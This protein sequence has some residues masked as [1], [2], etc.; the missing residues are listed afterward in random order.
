[1]KQLSWLWWGVLV[2]I[3]GLA[4]RVFWFTQVPKGM[5]RDEASL[6]YNAYSILKTGRDEYGKLLP[7]LFTS[8]GDQKLGGYVY[9]ATPFIFIFGLADWVVKLPALI[10][11]ISL[12]ILVG[13]FA[14]KLATQWSLTKKWSQSLALLSMISIAIS[15]WAIHFSRVAYEANLAAAYLL[16]ALIFIFCGREASH[17]SQQKRDWLIAG[18]LMGLSMLTYHSYL[19]LVPLLVLFLGLFQYVPVNKWKDGSVVW[20]IGPIIFT[21]LVLVQGGIIASNSQKSV[22]TSQFSSQA[23]L[24]DVTLYRQ[25]LP[26]PIQPWAK[27]VSNKYEEATLGLVHNVAK[28]I[29]GD[30]FFVSGMNH[31]AHN[32]GNIPNFHLWHLPLIIFGIFFVWEKRHHRGSLLLVTWI[33]AGII[34]PAVTTTPA[35]TTRLSPIFPAIEILAALGM[36]RLLLRLKTTKIFYVTILIVVVLYSWLVA[37]WAIK[38]FLIVPNTI[39]AEE[40]YDQLASL[41]RKY[42]QA[43]TLILTHSPSSSPYIWYLF[44]DKFNPAQFRNQV[45]RYPVDAEYFQHV[46]AVGQVRFLDFTSAEL[47]TLELETNLIVITQ[48]AFRA[49]KVL[50]MSGMELLEVVKDPHGEVIWEVWSWKVISK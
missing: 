20:L 13:I 44:Q 17:R 15:P 42:R 12:I 9:A 5:N 43:D 45:V 14:Y 37:R 40:K 21:G 31:G 50:D 1:M 11:G 38:Y 19:F 29:S 25:F 26:T 35:H 6:G 28:E 10:A 32:P 39:Q 46:A 8:F 7:I 30:F 49:D 3:L 41:I 48:P 4:L 24:R 36:V 16:G 18:V 22:G 33:L 2:V 27:I 47:Q 34:V 23:L